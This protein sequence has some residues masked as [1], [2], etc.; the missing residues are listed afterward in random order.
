VLLTTEPSL[1]PRVV[2]FVHE[3][4]LSLA[5]CFFIVWNKQLSIFNTTLV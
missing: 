1:Q 3:I 2:S 4:F 5:L